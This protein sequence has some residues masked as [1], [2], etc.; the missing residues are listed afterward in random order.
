MAQSTHVT[1][2]LRGADIDDN[3]E[4][5][6]SPDDEFDAAELDRAAQADGYESSAHKEA[7]ETDARR[8]GWRPLAEYRGKP[9]GW[10]DAKTFIQ[11]GK[12]YLPF[13]QKENREMKQTMGNMTTEMEGLRTLVASTQSDMKKL[14]AYSRQASQAGYDRAVADLKAQQREAAAAGDVSTFDKIEGQIND[15]DAARDE[16][17]DTETAPAGDPP[18]PRP[19]PAV[20]IDP[21]LQDFVEANPWF[22]SDRVLNSAMIA[23]HT[24]ILNESPGMALAEQLEKAKEAVMARHPKK[25]G[26]S[27]TTRTDDPPPRRPA[28]PLPPSNRPRAPANQRAGL[29]SIEDPRER[30]EARK[31]F[32]QTRRSMPDITEAEYLEIYQNPH[33][34]VLDVR[35]Q[36]REAA[37][38]SK[39]N[40]R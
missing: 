18:P 10:V 11:R 30:A 27:E 8:Q 16:V 32:E 37:S 5:E 36:Q 19:K 7:D 29:D 40:G 22:N 23:E 13:V 12:D 25:F 21:A 28:A 14:L 24:A 3:R 9:G 15:M 4:G 34:D 1:S 31:G 20:D 26:L 35:R 39:P 38:R 2:S 33:A 6:M 17:Q